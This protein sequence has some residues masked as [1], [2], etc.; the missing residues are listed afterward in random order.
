MRNRTK[1]TP[2]IDEK[3]TKSSFNHRDAKTYYMSNV[4]ENNTIIMNPKSQFAT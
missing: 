3:Q 2:I 4:L 1:S